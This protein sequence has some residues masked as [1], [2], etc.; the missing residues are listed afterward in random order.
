MWLL[1][2]GVYWGADT[3]GYGRF[4]VV[5]EV[6]QGRTFG[7]HGTVGSIYNTNEIACMIAIL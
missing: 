5:A 4:G 1:T 3:V 6:V 2:D 7:A